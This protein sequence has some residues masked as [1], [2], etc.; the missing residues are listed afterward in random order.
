MA[1]PSKKAKSA[2]CQAGELSLR[3]APSKINSNKWKRFLSDIHEESST[4]SGIQQQTLEAS[5]KSNKEYAK[6]EQISFNAIHNVI[7]KPPLQDTGIPRVKKPKETIPE[8]K[9][10]Y[11]P[12]EYEFRISKSRVFPA[13]KNS[14]QRI[15][16]PIR[17][18]DYP[19]LKRHQDIPVIGGEV[20][21]DP[22]LL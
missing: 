17:L 18:K 15:F 4:F 20:V 14:A 21:S 9:N 19:D 7:R 6:C 11:D 12:F 13:R 22:L 1:S 16:N 5:L 3:D 8:I 10:A 2:L